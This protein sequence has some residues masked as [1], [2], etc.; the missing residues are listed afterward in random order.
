M[1]TIIKPTIPFVLSTALT[2]IC[3]YLSSMPR[4]DFIVAI[5]VTAIVSGTVAYGA[6][7]VRS[8]RVHKDSNMA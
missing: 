6:A 2:A 4:F 3:C 5:I 7:F 8:R 1:K